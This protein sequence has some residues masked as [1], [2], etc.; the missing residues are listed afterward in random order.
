MEKTAQENIVCNAFSK[1]LKIQAISLDDNFFNIGG[2]SLKALEVAA[3]ISN[4]AKV[5]INDIFTNK[6]PR[7]IA[8]CIAIIP[9]FM[10]LN[11]NKI[12]DLYKINTDDFKRKC[13]LTNTIDLPKSITA[14]KS[15]KM[16]LLTGST[17]YLGC[18]V[19]KQLLDLTDYNIILPIRANSLTELLHKFNNKFMFYFGK[20]WDGSKPLNT[21]I[22][23]RSDF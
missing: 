4:E 2:N 16:I 11:F 17:G 12:S 14:D 13:L 20:L 19:L 18:N 15:I 7:K 8:E 21:L 9:A 23:L 1:V 5:N 6:T 3:T 10:Q 22:N